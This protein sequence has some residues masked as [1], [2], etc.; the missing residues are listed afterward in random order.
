MEK[1]FAESSD[2]GMCSSGRNID[3][4]ESEFDHQEDA[5]YEGEDIRTKLLYPM[6][7][8]GFNV[9]FNT[10]GG[11]HYPHIWNCIFKREFWD[12][13]GLRFRAYINF[14]DDLLVKTEALSKANKVS[15][16]SDMG[17]LWRV[18]LKSETYAHHFVENIGQKQD[19]EYNDMVSSLYSFN[20]SQDFL[21]CF[22]QVKHCKQYLD[23]VHYLTSPE[24]KKTK[25]FIKKYYEDNIYNRDFAE[26][27]EGYKYLGKGRVKPKILLPMLAKHK[28]MRSYRMEIFLD[29]VLL[30]TLHSSFL[31]RLERRIKR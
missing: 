20:P 19:M 9:P 2:M 27:I 29:R 5:T 24:V 8:N 28:T 14:E 25:E 16:I 3:G 18:N 23:A 21:N 12:K 11:N 1:M 7:F 13:A 22:K 4:N 26:S 31:T 10:V 17:Y 30:F 6:L 15:T